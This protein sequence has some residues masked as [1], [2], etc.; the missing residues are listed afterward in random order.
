MAFVS[1]QAAEYGFPPK[2]IKQIELAVEEALVNIFQHAYPE[3]GGEVELRWRP[4]LGR[5]GPAID[6]EDE[7]RPFDVLTVS[8]PDL[9]ADLSGRRVGGLGIYF[10]K[11]M[12]PGLSY[13]REGGKNILTLN[14]DPK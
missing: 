5:Q 11:K 9:E 10:L 4:G 7:G 12:V 6:I 2:R 14:L 3:G 13:R 1:A 8:D